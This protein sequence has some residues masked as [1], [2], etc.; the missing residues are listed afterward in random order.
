VHSRLTVLAAV[1]LARTG[2]SAAAVS[3]QLG[4]PRA[5]VRDW[6]SG[7]VPHSARAGTCGRCHVEHSHDRL[8]GEYAYVLGLY[9]GDG[10]ISEHPRGVAKLRIFLDLKYPEIICEASARIE[11]IT[12]RPAGVL[13]RPSNCVEVYSFWRAWP[14]LIPQHGSGKKHERPIALEG[15]QQRIVRTWPQ[16]LLRGLIQS[17]GCRFR[18]T[19]RNGWSHARYS[20]KNHSDDIH[21]VFRDACELLGVRWT[22]APH[23]TYVSRQADVATLD[24]FIGPKR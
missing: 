8:A 14:C 2:A 1:E 7:S 18:N 12:G 19:G 20:F 3:S 5:T 13:R 6:L 22:A 21:G 24:E 15:W 11:G 9:L 16:D 17:D 10:C 23:T 4:V